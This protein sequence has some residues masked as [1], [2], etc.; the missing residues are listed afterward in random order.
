M[1]DTSEA[2]ALARSGVY[3]VADGGCFGCGKDNPI[4]LRLSFDICEDGVR[5]CFTATHNYQGYS[6]VVH[7]GLVATMLD[8]ALAWAVWHAHGPAVTAE[9]TMR[10]RHPVLIDSRLIISGRA[11]RRRL[12]MVEAEAQIADDAGQVLVEGHGKFILVKQAC[13]VV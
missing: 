8:E 12:N 13:D 6:S 11:T 5:T 2:A 9:L 3:A 10:H 7:G 4:G 1:V